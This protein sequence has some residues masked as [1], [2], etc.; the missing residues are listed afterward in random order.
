[1]ETPKEQGQAMIEKRSSIR[2]EL[3]SFLVGL[4]DACFRSC[5]KIKWKEDASVNGQSEL[6]RRLA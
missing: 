3:P 1:V 6:A 4:L 5:P 2:G